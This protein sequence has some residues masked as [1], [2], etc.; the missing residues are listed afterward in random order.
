MGLCALLA[1]DAAVL[2]VAARD[3]VAPYYPSSLDQVQYLTE[4][5]AGFDLLR[6]RGVVAGTIEILT[7]PRAQGMLAEFVSAYVF[8]LTG[9]ARLPALDL[10][11]AWS[12]AYLG[13]TAI[14]V[15]RA[16]GLAPAIAA[17]GLMLAPRSTPGLLGGVFDFRL[18]LQGMCMWGIL[19]AFV[20]LELPRMRARRGSGPAVTLC[21]VL[22]SVALCLTRFIATTYLVLWLIAILSLSCITD[23]GLRAQHLVIVRRTLL[24]SLGAVVFAAGGFALLNW[25]LIREY[26]IG[27]HVFSD[28]KAFRA[29]EVGVTSLASSLIFYPFS[30]ARDQAGPPFIAVSGVL[31]GVAAWAAFAR[32]QGARDL[33]D[34]IRPLLPTWTLVTLLLSVIAPYV[35]LTSDEAKSTVVANAFLPPAVLGVTWLFAAGLAATRR[36]A[37]TV[38]RLGVGAGAAALTLGFGAQWLTLQTTVYDQ[39]RRGEAAAASQFMLDVGDYVRSVDGGHATWASDAHVDFAPNLVT[40]VYYYEQRHVWLDLPS[41]L[42]DGPLT[43]TLSEDQVLHQAGGSD[44]LLLTV[45]YDTGYPYDESISQ[46]KSALFELAR[47][48]YSLL[49]QFR[50]H[51]T[52]VFAF[53]R[54]KSA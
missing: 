46:A 7:Q 34:R 30:A 27:G 29:L 19:L 52:D 44:I 54:S 25:P 26:Y 47:Q 45:G 5:Y 35:V 32:R 33:V 48:R 1:F 17:T 53:V 39:Q 23:L 21:V 12:V 15:R 14:L 50:I 6:A 42:G 13:L 38:W 37:L 49:D 40:R 18:D 51:G 24:T 20:L 10:N 36:C 41:R 16:L 9:P 2:H 4:S 22:V 8:L 3:A 43:Q 31:L 11:I 28:E